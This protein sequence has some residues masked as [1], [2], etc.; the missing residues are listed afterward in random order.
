MMETG[1]RAL[2]RLGAAVLGVFV[3]AIL[4]GIFQPI[5]TDEVGWRLQ[6]RAGFDGVDKLLTEVCGPNTLARPPFWMMPA[7]Y[8]SALFNGLF[9]EPIYVRL[10]GILYALIFT[11]TILM[12]IGRVA[13]TAGDRISLSILALGLLSLG[14]MPILLVWSRPEQPIVLAFASALLIAFGDWNKGEPPAPNL[15]TASRTAWLRSLA[16]LLLASVALSYHV[17][18]LFTVPIFLACIYFASRGRAAHI[19][20]IVTALILVAITAW[21][22]QYWIHR[23]ECP[24]APEVRAMFV[25]NNTGAALVGATGWSQ[26]SPLLAKAFENLSLFQYLGMPAPRTEPISSWL[27]AHR[28]S[29]H[30]SFSWF[31]VLVA[32]WGIALSLSAFCLAGAPRRAWRQRRLDARVVFAA[33]LIAGILGWSA[34]QGFRNPYEAIFVVPMAVLAVIL[35]LATREEG[36]PFGGAIQPFTVVVG[37]LGMGSVAIMAAIYGPVTLRSTGERGYLKEQPFSISAF[38]YAGLR[39]D[40]LAAARKCGI[41]D[42]DAKYGLTLDDVTYFTFMKSRMPEHT[43]GMFLGDM[44]VEPIGYLK[45]VKSEG[46]VASCKRL[47]PELQARAKREGQFCCIAPPS[48]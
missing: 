43:N 40:M 31:L 23:L 2:S 47:P 21:A 45:S 33:L 8:Y 10:S 24:N 41:A 35:A 42:P 13:R 14:T 36:V 44:P 5:Y 26:I 29:L 38:G 6:E 34:S 1:T 28:V 16:V 25:G 22:A 19:P 30:T 17:K 48:W 46:I 11:A 27:P 4:S 15:D 3:L 20:R 39:R 9:A 7:R 18:A 37:L 32:L 12:L